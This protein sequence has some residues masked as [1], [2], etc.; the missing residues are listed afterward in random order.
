MDNDVDY[1]CSHWFK[2]IRFVG[3]VIVGAVAAAGF[4]FLFGYFVM[5]LWNWLMPG[6]FGLSTLTFWQAFGVIL[7]ARLIFG[8]FRHG[9]DFHRGNYSHK[10]KFFNYC[11]SKGGGSDSMK[12][13]RY[14]DSYWCDE[15]EKSFNEYVERKKEQTQR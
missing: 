14:F 1:K 7:L 3:F 12:D 5:L 8:G 4:A 10:R 2:G 6:L 13:W 15:G 9:H 11:C